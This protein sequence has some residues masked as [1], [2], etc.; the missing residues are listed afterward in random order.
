MD[1]VPVERL[2]LVVQDL[3]RWAVEIPDRPVV[4]EF[5][6]DGMF[7]AEPDLAAHAKDVLAERGSEDR[8][9]A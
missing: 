8:P 7:E 9:T 5:E 4:R 2:D 6:L 1:A 3:R